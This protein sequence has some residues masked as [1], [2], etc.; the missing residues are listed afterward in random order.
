VHAGFL[1]ATAG[2]VVLAMTWGVPMLLVAATVEAFGNGVLRPALT[3][4][5]T[6]QVSRSEQGTVLGLNQSLLSIA[7][8]V[9]PALAGFLIDRGWLSA[10]ATCTAAVVFLGLWMS[11]KDRALAAA[12]A[13]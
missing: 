8:I 9:A 11:R 4:L 5:I 1:A 10:W 13:A 7:Q 12:R 3:S 6:Q 2:Y